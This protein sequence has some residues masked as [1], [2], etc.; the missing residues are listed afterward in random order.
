MTRKMLTI[1][2][3]VYNEAPNIE[4]LFAALAPVLA[5]LQA[6]YDVELL[7]T[8]N[9]S[10]DATFEKLQARGAVDP[11]V[12]VL[13]FSRNF[14][15]Q[16]SILCGYLNARGDAAIQID[17]DLQDPPALIVQFVQRWQ[18]GAKVV[19]GVRRSRKEGWLI[20]VLRQAFYRLIDRLSDT[21]L[22]LDAG[23]FR[24]VDRCVIDEL[25]RMED[26]HPYL[27]GA[28][29]AMGFEQVGI[30]YDRSERRHGE[31]KFPLSKL[32]ALAV[33][34]ILNHSVVP[35]RLATY[36]GL[37]VSLLTLGMLVATVIGRLL[38]GGAWPAG[39]ATLTVLIL[40]SL[41]L[42]ALFLGVIGEYLGRIYQ[43]VKRRSLTIVEARVN[44]PPAPRG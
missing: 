12:R 40:L 29:A 35:L 32:V 42:N 11:R 31:S 39:F 38:Y 1:L 24:L 36:T 25:G 10:E 22:P 28:I 17:C 30:P 44:D 34:G 4:P 21:R 5:E 7:F 14:G 41:S 6:S 26:Y 20:T 13:R 23:D 18:A 15:F 43:Q 9:H 16:R 27:R 33:D 3:P 37:A 8:D 2:V 19:Y